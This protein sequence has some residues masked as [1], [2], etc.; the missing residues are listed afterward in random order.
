MEL[1]GIIVEEPKE[2]KRGKKR[3]VEE[4]VEVEPRM[5][6]VRGKGKINYNIIV[7]R[8]ASTRSEAR[9]S[10]N[11]TQPIIKELY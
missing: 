2:I 4:E 8:F 5:K 3:N 6:R 9:V 10:F 11:K 7:F 1:K